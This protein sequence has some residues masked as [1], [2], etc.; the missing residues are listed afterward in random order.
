MYFAISFYLLTIW[1]YGLSVS[2]GLF[3]PCLATGAAWGRL[4]GLGVHCV[5]PNV[6]RL[7]FYLKLYSSCTIYIKKYLFV[8]FFVYSFHLLI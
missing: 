3:I 8:I 6:V 5:F 1:T 4:I 2:A 7:F